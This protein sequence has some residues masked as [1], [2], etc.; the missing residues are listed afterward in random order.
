[1]YNIILFDLDGTLTDPKEGITKS[2]QYAL[3]HFGIEEPNLDHLIPFIGPPL[4]QSFME[5]YGFEEAVAKAAITRYRE[6]FSTV[7]IFENSVYDGIKEMLEQ[8]QQK[9]KILTIATSKP[10]IFAEQI[11]E[12]YGI[13]KYFKIVVGSELDGRRTNKAEVIEEVFSQLNISQEEKSQ[14][15]MIGDRKHDIIGAKANGIHSIG[16]KFGYAEEN[17]LELAGADYIV[18]TVEELRQLLLKS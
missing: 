3:I 1:M 16:V 9:G 8:L 7:G 4:L 14:A 6:R 12:H 2:V 5:F 13:R 15:I 18:E 11:L 10:G 17:E